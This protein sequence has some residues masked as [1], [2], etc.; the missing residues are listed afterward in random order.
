M[1][2]DNYHRRLKKNKK[3]HHMKSAIK[4]LNASLRS[5]L[6]PKTRTLQQRTYLTNLLKKSKNVLQE[7]KQMGMLMITY[8][9]TTVNILLT[10]IQNST[11]TS[12][13]GNQQRVYRFDASL[14]TEQKRQRFDTRQSAKHL[15][16]EKWLIWSADRLVVQ[17]GQVS[18]A[19]V[20]EQIM[21]IQWQNE[22]IIMAHSVKNHKHLSVILNEQP[23]KNLGHQN[24]EDEGCK[25]ENVIAVGTWQM[26]DE[27]G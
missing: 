4:W 23:L 22:H 11:I 26:H 27:L 10:Q 18:N 16:P 20:S 7:L 8:Q 17:S 14:S 5:N 12:E 1:Q 25:A 2:T 24:P 21:Y 13:L 6:V 19:V 9:M 3:K 15:H